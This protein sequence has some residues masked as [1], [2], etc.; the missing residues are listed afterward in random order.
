MIIAFDFDGTLVDSYSCIEEAF[1]RALEKRYRWLPGKKLWA[2][3]LTK[4]EL[5]F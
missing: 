3:L 5:Q 1:L 4:I 2:K